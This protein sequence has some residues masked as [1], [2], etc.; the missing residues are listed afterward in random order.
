MAKKSGHRWRA[1]AANHREASLG[2]LWRRWMN[3]WWG[4]TLLLWMTVLP[5]SLWGLRTTWQQLATY[6]TWA[7]LRYGLAFERW[8]ALGLGL[9]VGL[10]VALLIA[11]TRH[12]F[13][14]FTRRERYQLLRALRRRR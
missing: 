1:K 14:G 10:G 6:F 8:A 2:A 13:W 12:L 7:A 5:L 4:I 11:E 3:R 9:C